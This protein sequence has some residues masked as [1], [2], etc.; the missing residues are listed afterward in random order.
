MCNRWNDLVSKATTAGAAVMIG[1]SLFSNAV[2]IDPCRPATPG[3]CK[4]DGVC[5][6]NEIEW[7][8][9]RTRWRTW[10]GE[11]KET[12]ATP[13]AADPSQEGLTLPPLERPNPEDENLRGPAKTTTEKTK[14]DAA[15]EGEV[16]G[17]DPLQPGLDPVQPELNP[18]QPEADDV[19]E[20]ELQGYQNLIPI[21]AFDAPP[22]LPTSLRKAAIQ[23]PASPAPKT[24]SQRTQQT[25]TTRLVNPAKTTVA[26]PAVIAPLQ[27]AKPVLP[28]GLQAELNRPQPVVQANVSSS[29]KLNLVNPA[30][31]TVVPQP[32]LN[33]A[34]FFEISD[35]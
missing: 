8:H 15:T 34:V 13:D 25:S 21:P 12:G 22:E 17:L 28:A 30:A 5:R 3:P 11:K 27:P 4:A 23:P 31:G 2:A 18:V 14:Q 29:R 19:P 26:I 32:K 16:Q 33:N 24:S 35:Q 6:P 20:F 7:G 10:P 1:F 9:Y